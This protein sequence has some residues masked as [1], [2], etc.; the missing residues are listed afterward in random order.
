MTLTQRRSVINGNAS[1]PIKGYQKLYMLY[2]QSKDIHLIIFFLLTFLINTTISTM[3]Q[4]DNG[5]NDGLQSFPGW[6]L[7]RKDVSRV[8]IIP[9]ETISY[10]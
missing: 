10:D 4:Q 7:S 1:V 8:V 2:M 5:Q 3:H 6:S 9:D